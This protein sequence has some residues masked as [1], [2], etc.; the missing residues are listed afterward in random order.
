MSGRKRPN[1]TVSK[2][3][4]QRLIKKFLQTH[5]IHS[6]EQLASLLAEQSV[7]VTQTTLSRDL[8]ELEVWKKQDRYILGNSDDQDY[9]APPVRANTSELARVLKDLL[10]SA[11]VAGTLV[12]LKTNPGRAQPIGWELDNVD[13]PLVVGN[14][15]G[16]DTIFIATRSEAEA[17]SLR[18]QLIAFAELDVAPD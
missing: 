10:V 8:A 12:V 16:D 7:K 14:I 6:Q 17:N 18:E 13:L 3:E 5:Q 11:E 2:S 1:G 15:S 9:P 4:R